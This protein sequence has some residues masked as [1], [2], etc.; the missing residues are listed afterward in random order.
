MAQSQVNSRDGSFKQVDE[1]ADVDVGLLVVEVELPTVG[2]LGGHVVGKD[3]SLEA[4]A[5][6]VFELELCVEAVGSGPCLGQGE[7]G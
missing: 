1:G 6:V 3:L 5:E 2:A 7:P 4:F